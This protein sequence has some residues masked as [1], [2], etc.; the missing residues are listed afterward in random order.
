MME[1][2]YGQVG[3]VHLAAVHEAEQ[4]LEH[5]GVSAVEVDALHPILDGVVL[6][7]LGQ[8]GTAGRHDGAVSEKFR[9]RGSRSAA[10]A[11]ISYFVIV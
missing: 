10:F 3:A 2:D 8:L 9:D 1:L 7:K 5:V 6:E 4:V 11:L